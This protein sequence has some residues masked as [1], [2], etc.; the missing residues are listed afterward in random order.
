MAHRCGFTEAVLRGTLK[1]AGF[2]SIVTRNR[3]RYFDLWALASKDHRSE[4]ELRNLAR[5]HFPESPRV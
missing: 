2:S 4:D 3:E 1:A 5:E